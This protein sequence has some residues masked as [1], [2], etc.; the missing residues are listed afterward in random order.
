V[1]QR[2]DGGWIDR[3]GHVMIEAGCAGAFD[4]LFLAPARDGNKGGSRRSGHAP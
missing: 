2:L 4:V 1:K 3:L